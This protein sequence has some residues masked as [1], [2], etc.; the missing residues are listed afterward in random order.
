MAN[1]V[2]GNIAGIDIPFVSVVHD[3]LQAHDP[4]F[5][6]STRALHLAISY[7]IVIFL[8]YFT[9]R[10]FGLDLDILF[11]MAGAMTSLVLITFTPSANRRA[12]AKSF[13]K[14]FSATF[15][16]LLVVFIIG[17]GESPLNEIL[18][19][20]LLIPLS[21]AALY[22]RRYGMEGQRLGLAMVII[23]TV[24]AT[25]HPGRLELA[26]LLAASCQGAL[27]AAVVRL[28]LPRPSAMKVYHDAVEAAGAAIGGYLAELAFAVRENRDV[29]PTSELVL[30]TVRVRVRSALVNATAEAPSARAYIE[31]VR[32]LA[33]RL[34]IATQLLGDC[35][36]HT[37][38]ADAPWRMPL[39]AAADLL[40]RHLQGGLSEPFPEKA[41]MGSAISRLRQVAMAQDQEP[42]EQ[43]AL[44]RAVTAFE[45][46]SLVVSELSALQSEGA[47]ARPQTGAGP[48][49]TALP[50][51]KPG[52]SPYTKVAIQGLVAT[53]IT[54]SM[55]F[56][57]GLNHAYW[58]TMTV[59]FVLGNSVGET[60]VRARYRSLGT[61]VGV[62][63][64]FACLL[65]L[66][67]NIWVLATICL[68]SQMVGLVT[69]RDR[70][71]V[72][73][74]AVGLSVIV[75]LHL[76]ANLGTDGMLARIYETAIG[77]ITALVIAWL[78]LPVYVA[79]QIRLQVAD[80]LRR[81]R[82]AFSQAWPNAQ[83]TKGRHLTA[84]MAL[85][86]RALN[87]RLPQIGAETVLGHRSAGEVIA[88][89]ST[90]EVLTTYLA[91]LEDV[92]HRL[93]TLSPPEQITTALEAARARTLRAFGAALGE[94]LPGAA[95]PASAPELEAA[96]PI[97][98]EF[99]SDPETR[100]LLPFVAD[101]LSFS[102]AVL[103]PLSDLGGILST[104]APAA[105]AKEKPSAPIGSEATAT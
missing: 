41:R 104:T 83:G 4:G 85:D 94:A 52:L 73:S 62:L 44:L 84:A 23:M 66:E 78:V 61:I 53:A 98:L 8:G 91:L 90:L 47:A 12:E 36:P 75:A 40:A 2:K 20:L 9:S 59:V 42:S 60:Y 15:G 88:L 102:E 18:L 69:A 99:A 56:T 37:H 6:D 39:A 74:A 24:A 64:G 70:Y 65:F 14:I 11:P 30:D 63:L 81:C 49:T 33:Y 31:A 27:V 71:D 32:S 67:Q 101:Y 35:V 17:P 34:R 5:V 58:A 22:I 19:K 38:A 50:A 10:W 55:D 46:L 7:T 16:L 80:L 25:L 86:L 72:S 3:W 93:D 79:D 13:A 68:L 45:R 51:D 43:L 54:T 100:K 21:A 92:A 1:G 89:V 97:A 82:D 28:T 26:Y 48:V 76:I 87:D 105:P 95:P 77:A 29:P 96:L 57:L 103:R